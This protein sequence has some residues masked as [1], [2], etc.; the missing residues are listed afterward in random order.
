MMRARR[1][2]AMYSIK[3]MADLCGLSTRALRHFEQKGLLR[4]QRL[5][6]GYRAYGEQEVARLQHLLFYRELG[7]PLQDIKGILDRQDF[8]SKAALQNHLVQLKEKAAR[9]ERLI[10]TLEKTIAHE[11]GRKAMNDK[12]KFEGFKK[13]QIRQNEE[14]YGKEIREKYGDQAIDESNAKL[15][16][17]SKADHERSLALALQVNDLLKQV[18]AEKNSTGETARQ[19]YQAHKDWL[20]CYWTKY[21][22]QAHAA[23]GQMYVDDERFSKYYEDVVPGGAVA[24]R[25]VLAA[26]CEP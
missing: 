18:V 3:E 20:M 13:E 1:Q 21:N 19:L 5:G 4:P 24:L 8:D 10:N 22:A 11:E 16:G 23:L 12:E 2:E 7:L 25:D 26:F 9:M 14:R 6:N 15:M 17:Q